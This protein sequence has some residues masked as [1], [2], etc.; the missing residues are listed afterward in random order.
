MRRDLPT[1]TVT[2]VF[3]D[4]EGST[5]MLE[6]LGA[7]AYGELLSRHH[8][9]CRAAWSRHGGVEVDTAGDAFFVAFPTASG[10]LGAAA[11]AQGALADLGLRV[12][13]GVH[14]GEVTVAETGYVGFE[15]HRAARIAGA[16][17][18][19]Q[20]VV[21]GAAAAGV[22]TEQLLDL[23]EHRF[24]DVDEPVVIFQLGR[25]SFPP[26][27]TISNTNL[28]RPA[29][30]F[31]GRESELGEVLSR[32]DA[33]ARLV[34]LTGPGGSGKTRLAIEAATALVP[35]AK[36]G[37][38]WVGLATLRD[39]AL[40]L[41][42][43]G[44]AL[45]AKGALAAHIGEREMLLLLDNL[46]QVIDAAPAL[47]ALLRSCPGLRLLV[48]SRELLRVEG[49]VEYP[50]PP[51][52]EP[53]AVAL[54]CERAG[55]EPSAE[56][57]E[58]CARLDNL[59]LAVELAAARTKAL[60]A[61][62]ILERLSQRLDLL[63]GG[64]DADPR[65]QTLRATIEWSHELLD[66]EEQRL[67][68]ALSVFA[69]GCT[70]EAAEAVADADLDTLQ[71]LVEKS[72]VRFTNERYWML[73][74]I[75]EYA[76]ERVGALGAMTGLATTHAVHY[77]VLAE[78]AAGNTWDEVVLRRL[79]DEYVNLRAA[80]GSFIDGRDVDGAFRL[81]D[82]LAPYWG[83][84]E[85][86]RL[87]DVRIHVEAA[88]A[89]EQP[90]SHALRAKALAIASDCVRFQGD[91]GRARALGEASLALSR[92]LGDADGVARAL[93]ELGEAAGAEDDLDRS[94]A[95]FAE[96]V[97]VAHA[98]GRDG[99]ESVA[100]LGYTALLQ[101]D[102]ERARVVSEEAADLFRERGHEGDV[103]FSLA[104]R[105]QAT[106]LLGRRD[107]AR[108]LLGQSFGLANRLGFKGVIVECLDATGALLADE[109]GARLV[110]AADFLADEINLQRTPAEE[111]LRERM[112]TELRAA[113]GDRAFGEL[114]DA[115]RTMSADEA[116]TLALEVL[117]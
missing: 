26:L 52:A 35:D 50:V 105:A 80:L 1:G 78:R 92:Q 45:G 58:L 109:L 59:P 112:H 61:G 64:R 77:L 60:S 6:E 88:L 117:D 87:S 85:L 91:V 29:S 25:D 70:L 86:D 17:H 3:T 95:L 103:A 34:T 62:Q 106:L 53:E 27:K 14:T 101:G 116:V 75:R 114:R 33:G 67:F 98:A 32:F 47:S 20:V 104:N 84:R 8:D 82:A 57:R 49:E 2:F 15:V 102:Y 36:A 72:L 13:M 110:G 21:S 79:D 115:G 93:H 65:Q 113:L 99:A 18:G 56:I 24:K 22:D 12:R 31:V 81:I 66:D 37:V 46:E 89:I 76:T 44:Q 4:I 41:E 30:S 43:V 48:T 40:V 42:T 9:V 54:F 28:P 83:I 100:N 23:G 74:T 97:A 63:K 5:R 51:L 69:G 90:E 107:E 96:A 94:A 73:E 71:S 38:F 16:A 68:R 55:S 108:Q 7:D 11:A 39:P 10:A 111:R 19:G